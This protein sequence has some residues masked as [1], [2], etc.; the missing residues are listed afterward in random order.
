MSFQLYFLA[1]FISLWG[2][3]YDSV[4]C[5]STHRFP[6]ARDSFNVCTTTTDA[7]LGGVGQVPP[8]NKNPVLGPTNYFAN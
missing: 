5:W 6:A 2:S 3:T 7:R 1:I 8:P 4:D